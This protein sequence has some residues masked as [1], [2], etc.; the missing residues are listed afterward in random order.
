MDVKDGEEESCSYFPKL[1]DSEQDL[2]SN[3]QHGYQL[4]ID[5]LGGD[6]FCADGTTTK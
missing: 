1:I 6:L 4:E 2:L 5:L 3:M